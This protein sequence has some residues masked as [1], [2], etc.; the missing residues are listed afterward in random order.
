MAIFTV[1]SHGVSIPKGIEIIIIIMVFV[2]RA[3][4]YLVGI[5]ISFSFFSFCRYNSEFL[6]KS[7]RHVL[8]ISELSS[9]K[10]TGLWTCHRLHPETSKLGPGNVTT[11]GPI[12]YTEDE[13]AAD[14]WNLL[15]LKSVLAPALFVEDEKSKARI[16]PFHG[17]DTQKSLASRP[18]NEVILGLKVFKKKPE[19]SVLRIKEKSSAKVLCAVVVP[20]NRSSRSLSWSS[21]TSEGSSKTSPGS[22]SSMSPLD[23]S[24]QFSKKVFIQN[25]N[26]VVGYKNFV[27]LR[28]VERSSNGAELA[29][30]YDGGEKAAVTVHVEY[31]PTFTIHR[32]PAFGIP[33]VEGEKNMDMTLS[34]SIMDY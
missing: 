9:S 33:V 29:C 32:V 23:V 12:L 1:Y 28:D 11:E 6:S 15:V 22:S 16:T 17:W 8:T 19:S 30:A 10:D 31:P 4:R 25:E 2:L 20:D 27:T 14:A 13:S 34:N 18:C 24:S 21:K 26:G 7:G 5:L 3:G